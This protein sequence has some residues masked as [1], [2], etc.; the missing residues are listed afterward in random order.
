MSSK[1]LHLF[2]SLPMFAGIV[3]TSQA[4]SFGRWNPF[5]PVSSH[6]NLHALLIGACGLALLATYGI[7]EQL[8]KRLDRLEARLPPLR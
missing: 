1:K 4:F 2:N 7:L 3:V 8:I 5:Q 6:I